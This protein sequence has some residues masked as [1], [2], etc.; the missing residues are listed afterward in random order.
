MRGRLITKLEE[1]TLRMRCDCGWLR[2]KFVDLR[3]PDKETPIKISGDF[4]L[5][6]DC[7]QCGARWDARYGAV[8]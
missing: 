8:Q 7:P 4:Y 6:F 5:L 1:A 2:P 3:G